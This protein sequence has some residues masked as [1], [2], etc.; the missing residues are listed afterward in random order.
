MGRAELDLVTNLVKKDVRVRYMG[1]ALGFLWSLG[2]PALMTLTYLVV[3][4]FIF[5]NP[6]PKFILYLVT[7]IIHWTLFT[8]LTLQSCDWLYGNSNLIKKIKFPLIILPAAGAGTVLL[9]W[10]TSLTV[11][12]VAYTPLGGTASL[13]MIYYPL[14]LLSYLA[15]ILGIGLMLSVLYIKFRDIK[16]LVEIAMPVMFWLT[17]IVW[18]PSNLTNN[19]EKWLNFNPL[20]LYFKNF[21]NIFYHGVVPDPYTLALSSLLG[22]GVLTAGYLVFIKQSQYVVEEL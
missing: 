17:P 5:H 21:T 7:G 12:V 6:D 22:I 19:M 3:F 9:F 10:I 13:A 18:Q 20:S 2:N 14:V 1:S 15:F 11:Y 16:H 8:Q 4:K